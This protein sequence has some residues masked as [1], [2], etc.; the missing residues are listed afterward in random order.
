M[1]NK[2]MKE[3]CMCVFMLTVE[4]WSIIVVITLYHERNFGLMIKNKKK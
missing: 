4:G 1:N 3:K 2:K